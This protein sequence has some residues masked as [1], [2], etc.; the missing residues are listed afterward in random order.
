MVDS[1]VV[2]VASPDDFERIV[3]LER[4]CFEGDLAYSRRQLQYL[5]FAANSTTLVEVSKGI[6]RG[7]VIVLY[8]TGSSVAGIE[9]VN[10]DP[11]FRKK[12]VGT[13]LLASA[14]EDIR[15]KGARKI[16]LEVSIANHAG[17]AL[18]EHSGFKK[19]GLL[20]NYY[21]YNHEGSRD[22]IRMI[23]DLR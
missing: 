9:T 5:A 22:A 4:A 17:V 19:I 3:A 7:F 23:K 14:E 16:R 13:R 18:Y 11:V 2:R 20:K 21:S 6:I 12:G 8:R 1:P 15:R 10:V